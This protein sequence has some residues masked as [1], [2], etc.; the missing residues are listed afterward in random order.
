MITIKH[1]L[2]TRTKTPPATK[3]LKNVNAF[4]AEDGISSTIWRSMV[5]RG[6]RGEA[7]NKRQWHNKID[8]ICC[9]IFLK[10]SYYFLYF[11]NLFL[12][13]FCTTVDTY[14]V[15]SGLISTVRS[16][17]KKCIKIERFL[18]SISFLIKTSC[19]WW[20]DTKTIN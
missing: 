7:P 10:F 3:L 9:D 14:F 11:F 6:L 15:S 13:I 19:F 4:P 12:S 20:F 5:K 2:D 17:K 18:R 1:F 16:L 8:Q